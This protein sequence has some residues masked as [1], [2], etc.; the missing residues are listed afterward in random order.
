[1]AWNEPGNSGKDRDPWGN[2]GKNQ[3]SPDLD[4][5]LRNFLQ[6]LSALLGGRR[7]GGDVAYGETQNR[8]LGVAKH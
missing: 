7:P 1:M 8:K 3:T 5:V 6:K 2:S 4:K